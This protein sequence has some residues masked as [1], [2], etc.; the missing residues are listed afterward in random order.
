M[1]TTLAITILA[2]ISYEI[3][4][5]KFTAQKKMANTML[6]FAI[7]FA[8]TANIFWVWFNYHP[9]AKPANFLTAETATFIKEQ[10]SDG[11][12]ISLFAYQP[13][14]EIFL[15]HGWA[16]R[17]SDYHHFLNALDPNLNLV[18]NIAQARTYESMLPRREMFLESFINSG[19]FNNGPD[20][21]ATISARAI[22]LLKMQNVEFIISAKEINENNLKMVYQT[23]GNPQNSYRIY[24]LAPLPRFR[25][26]ENVHKVGTV[27]ELNQLATGPNFN[28]PNEAIVEADTGPISQPKNAQITP[29]KV[30]A[31]E[32]RLKVE[33]DTQAL[34]LIADSYYPGWIA[35]LDKKV[36]PIIPA[37]I[38]QKAVVIPPGQHELLLK[39]QPSSLKIGLLISTVTNLA[40]I[41]FCLLGGRLKFLQR[42][43]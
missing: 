21:A 23:S 27:A 38:N 25:F 11:R 28:P 3:F 1:L 16:N 10:K 7:Y 31:K 17:Q 2:A 19:I 13:W 5:Q 33:T 18:F 34:L 8:I 30:S 4:S 26:A 39:Y 43:F 36:T 6:F 22:E 35:Y 15:K 32:Y 41:L 12:I 14:N 42:Y 24:Q 20:K 9:T 40:L 37:N 29:L